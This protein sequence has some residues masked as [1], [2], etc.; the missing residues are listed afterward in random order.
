METEGLFLIGFNA[1]GIGQDT[2]EVD[3]RFEFRPESLH[4]VCPSFC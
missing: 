2:A 3:P 4:R 1:A